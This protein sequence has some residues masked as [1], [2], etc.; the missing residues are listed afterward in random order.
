VQM[1]HTEDK[2]SYRVRYALTQKA[3]L[4]VQRF[5]NELSPKTT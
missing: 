2:Y 3:R 1:F 5:Y 4:M